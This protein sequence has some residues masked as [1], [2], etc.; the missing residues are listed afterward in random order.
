MPTAAW[1]L[2]TIVAALKHFPLSW[3]WPS[4]KEIAFT[5]KG[6]FQRL[7][8]SSL[9]ERGHRVRGWITVLPPPS[10]FRTRFLTSG[11]RNEKS[12]S[13]GRTGEFLWILNIS[14]GKGW[15]W[16]AGKIVLNFQPVT[17]HWVL[18]QRG[19]DSSHDTHP[20]LQNGD[21]LKRGPC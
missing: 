1:V 16:D 7:G 8:E 21:L 17:C 10:N 4:Q 6:N 13:W 15:G 2:S 20:H 11:T 3:W 5:C 18:E 19:F 14:N 9:R 12:W